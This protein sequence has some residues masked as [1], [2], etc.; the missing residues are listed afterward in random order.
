M[1][2]SPPASNKRLIIFSGATLALSLLVGYQLAQ[3][4]ATRLASKQDKAPSSAQ[5]I[6]DLLQTNKPTSLVAADPI[7]VERPFW[8]D[9]VVPDPEGPD[10]PTKTIPPKPVR[11]TVVR[12]YAAEVHLLENGGEPQKLNDSVLLWFNQDPAAAT[13]WIN[14][15]ERFDDLI[16]S[17]GSLAEGIALQGQLDT[18][19]AWVEAVPNEAS[20]HETLL[21]I[22]AHEARQQRVNAAGL[23]QVG[24]SPED[25][26]KILSG[27]LDD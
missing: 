17:L 6:E 4:E 5:P 9:A 7:Q 22:Y 21:K 11:P 18:A 25:I 23:Q 3:P 14:E 27:A 24:F 12:D 8:E 20:R 26:S 16:P 2:W 15:T 1:K 13:A 10:L 19:L